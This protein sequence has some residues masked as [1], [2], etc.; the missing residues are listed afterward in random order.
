MGFE[1]VI[2]EGNP[3]NYT[4]RGF[5]TSCNYGIVAGPNIGLPA[6]ECLT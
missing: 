3:I 2:V 5:E 6:P 4:S 1:A